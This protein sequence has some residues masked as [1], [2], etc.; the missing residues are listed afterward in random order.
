[1]TI[2]IILIVSMLFLGGLLAT[3]GDRLG[4]KVGKA[5]LSLFNLRPR[6]TAVLV[7]IVT[8]TLIS[9]STL[10]VLFATSK[11][12]RRGI[13]EYDETQRKL[14]SARRELQSAQAQ[15][16][17]IEIELAQVRS[18]REL[19]QENL[20]NLKEGLQTVLIQ[21]SATEEILEKTQAQLK[22]IEGDF[23]STQLQLRD[24]VGKFQD[25]QN[26]LQA[27]TQRTETLQGE[28]DKLQ[29]ERQEL[30]QQRDEVKAQIAQR[31]L[32]IEERDRLIETR[33]ELID[34][35]N[36]LL[37]ERDRD[38]ETRNEAIAQRET[39][40]KALEEEQTFLEGR[41]RLFEQY[42][43]EYQD[44]RQ[45][46]LAL[47]RGQILAS[48]VVKVGE[49]QGSVDAINRLLD[50]ANQ[51]ALQQ[52]KPGTH[53]GN[54]RVI[55]VRDEQLQQWHDRIED[56]REYVVRVLS[57]GNYIPGETDVE[58]FTDVSLNRVV[59]TAGEAIATTKANPMFMNEETLLEQI[60]ILIE[61]SR[62]RARRGG[63]LG[64]SLQVADGLP[65]TL[66]NFVRQV[67]ATN[68]PVTIQAVA[69]ETTY[70]A[71]PL[72]LDLVAL[73]GN[74]ELFRTL[75]TNTS[76]DRPSESPSIDN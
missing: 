38:I 8:G 54:E 6:Q 63:I 34:E 66:L 22:Q 16:A 21:K 65:A 29:R 9:A 28:L 32:Q 1:M 71:G 39:R 14:R 55:Q 43:Q 44:L 5:R 19:V 69:A 12:L 3:L 67:E 4:T 40:L 20:D 47:L 31:D 13:F 64:N 51:V 61:S 7:T 68:A 24:V 60:D 52:V 2:G 23:Q 46:K 58:I 41:V 75:E 74:T 50:A 42:Y 10:V 62:F 48:A 73:Q 57:G 56:G 72:I 15:K 59:F 18:E 76:R 33:N 25:A 26:Q 17:Q 36:Q 70:T 45:G 30:I 11:P 35:R 49:G 37:L 27:V 53:Q